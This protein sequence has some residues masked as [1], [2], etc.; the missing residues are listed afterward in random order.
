MSYGDHKLFLYDEVVDLVIGS[1][2]LYVDNRPMNNKRLIAHKGLSNELIFNI[3][4]KDRKLQNVNSD[5]LRAT[6]FNNLSGK[7]I[8]TR[9]LE[10]TGTTG[11][12]KLNMAEGDLTNVDQGLYQLYISRETSE[13]SELPV[14]ADQNNN[15]KFD[16]EIKDQTKQTP[17]DTQTANV[18]QFIQVTNTN[19]G[20]NSNV[21][22]TSALK[23]NQKRNFTSC[24]HSIAIHPD[25]F[26]GNFSIQASCVEN[27][28]NTANNSSDWFNVVSNVS[29]TSNSTIYHHTFQVNANYVRV[30]SEPTAGN[31][32]LVQLRN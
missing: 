24:L 11:Q 8:F 23:G 29:L 22:V 4:N 17:V 28:P 14:F 21:F 7:R 15:I 10:H 13:G 9:V 2:G 12:V 30:L 27:T 16:I 3:R 19:N 6:L 31:I 25:T 26:T 5:I 18:S 32:S 1:D 20:D